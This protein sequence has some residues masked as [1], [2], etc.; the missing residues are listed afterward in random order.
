MYFFVL[1]F[2]KNVNVLV[3]STSV[4]PWMSFHVNTR[5][6]IQLNYLAID[7]YLEVCNLPPVI[8][9]ATDILYLYP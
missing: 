9:M 2:D 3:F 5:T 8:G 4:A 1:C 7:G 6:V